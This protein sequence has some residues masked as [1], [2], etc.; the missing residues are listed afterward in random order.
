DR[1]RW[2]DLLPLK[3]SVWVYLSV[4]NLPQTVQGVKQCYEDYQQM[5][6]QQKEAEAGHDLPAR[7]KRPKVKKAKVE[8][9]VSDHT[10]DQ[11][12]SIEDIEH[13]MDDWLQ[14][15]RVSKKKAADWT[16]EELS[17]LSRLMVKFPG[18]APGRWEKIAQDLGRSVTE[19]TAKVRQVKDSVS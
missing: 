18:G 2:R 7:E 5:K 9:P 14:E 6:Q 3:L 4:R 13:Q 8:F 16:E 1:P 17:L 12:A 10:Y 15:R 11:T 19:V